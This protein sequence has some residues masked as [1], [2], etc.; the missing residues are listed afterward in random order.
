MIMSNNPRVPVS[1]RKGESV[2]A[3]AFRLAIRAEGHM[4][5]A[6]IAPM[7]SMQEALLIGSINRNACDARRALFDQFK[8]LMKE[9]LTE[10]C[11]GA[12]GAAPSGFDERQA[13]EHEKSGRA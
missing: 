5:N 12:L 1:A 9:V 10:A 8:E 2:N 3:P 11:K 4:I 13:P 7:D 6:Y